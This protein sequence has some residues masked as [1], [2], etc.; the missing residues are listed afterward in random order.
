M[1]GNRDAKLKIRSSISGGTEVFDV[2][3]KKYVKLSPEEEVR[4]DFLR[5]LV[6]KKHF[7]A[8]LISV[9]KG[10]TV[11]GLQKR[12]DAVAYNNNGS[13]LVLMEFKSSSV[14]MKQSV[15]DQVS[16]YNIILKVKY[17]IVS[18]GITNYCCKVNYENEGIEFLKEIPDYTEIKP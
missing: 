17:L 5:F 13:P 2:F 8:S 11:N 6:S 12:F 7:P 4:Q 9:E 18:N 10:L 1:P 16:V 14:K 3:R 15:F